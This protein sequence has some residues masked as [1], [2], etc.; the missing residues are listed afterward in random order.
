MRDCAPVSPY[1]LMLFGGA[2][3]GDGSGV[4]RQPTPRGGGGDENA[5]LTVDEWIKFRVPTLLHCYRA[6]RMPIM[7]LTTST[8]VRTEK[9]LM[10]FIYPRLAPHLLRI[11]SQYLLVQYYV[12]T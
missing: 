2:L 7:N 11:T 3:S 9:L 8:P 12:T 6:R 10:N 4:R 5:V 1:A